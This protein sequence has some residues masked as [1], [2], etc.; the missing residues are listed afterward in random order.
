MG[1]DKSFGGAFYRAQ[2]AAG[3][4]LPSHGKVFLS[5]KDDDK[6][7]ILEVAPRLL[8]MGLTL[9]ATKGTAEY[10][11]SK[12]IACESINKVREGS[13]HVVDALLR[14]EIAMVVNTPEGSGPLLDS[15]SIRLVSGDMKVPTFTTI[16]AASAAVE[17]I[18]IMRDNTCFGVSSL[19]EY[20]N[21][22]DG[23][24]R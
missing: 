16:A 21:K 6:L 20:L 15:T 7:E 12:G 8:E 1:I 17:A 23:H 14:G 19:Q 5:V 24:P 18:R 9:V 2:C 4:S 3:I 22:G 10:L 13:P 11:G